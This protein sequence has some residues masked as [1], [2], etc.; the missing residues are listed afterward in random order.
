MD[1]QVGIVVAWPSA[2]AGFTLVHRSKEFDGQQGVDRFGQLS[3]SF[4]Y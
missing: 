3:I 4:A 1:V 2:R